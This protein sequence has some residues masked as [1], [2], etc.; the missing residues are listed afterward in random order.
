MKMI[1]SG[2]NMVGYLTNINMYASML[3]DTEMKEITLCSLY[4]PG[5]MINWEEGKYKEV[6]NVTE[7]ENILEYK[8][9][10]KPTVL[11]RRVFTTKVGAA[12]AKD[13]CLKM[14]ATH[15]VIGTQEEDEKYRTF[16]NNTLTNNPEIEDECSYVD[17]GTKYDPV[18]I[19]AQHKTEGRLEDS[20]VLNPYTGDIITYVDWFPGWPNGNFINK[21]SYWQAWNYNGGDSKFIHRWSDMPFCFTCD[22]HQSILPILRMRGLCQES[23]FDKN[24]VLAQNHDSVMFYQGDRHTNITYSSKR[25]GWVIISNR[26]I[27]RRRPG[28][29]TEDYIVTGF[30]KVGNQLLRFYVK[31]CDF[32]HL[33]MDFS[34]ENQISFLI[35]MEV[36]ARVQTSPAP[37]FLPAVLMIN[38]LAKMDSASTWSKDVTRSSTVQMTLQMKRFVLWS[39]MNRHIRRSLPRSSWMKMK[40]LRR[41][42]ST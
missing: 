7:V 6:G 36:V 24:Y 27:N 10:C 28:A 13:V 41:Q 30:S 22:G 40:I 37:L 14:H 4:K 29:D 20:P 12:E 33:L 39:T 3:N 9:I 16:I 21:G 26:R 23:Q 19:L 42:K 1:K 18:F 8:D 2:Q 15:S 5:D 32:R 31:F 35:V 11:W 38:L 34:W 25:E 17:V